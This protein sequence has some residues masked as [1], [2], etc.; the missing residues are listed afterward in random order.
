MPDAKT[1]SFYD[2]SA[3]RYAELTHSNA[4]SD[5]LKAFMALLPEG[6]SVLDLGCGPAQAS[7]YMRDKGF[8]PDPVDASQ[9]MIDLA[10]VRYNIGARKLTFDELDMVNTYDGVWANF[11]LLHTAR[12]NLPRYLGSIYTALHS[13]GVFHIAMKVGENTERDSLDRLY[14]YV[15][16]DELKGLLLDVGFDVLNIVEGLEI[17]C[18]GTNDS[19]VV[20]RAIK[21][22]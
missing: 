17:G 20:I 16:V 5:N 6:G 3:E 22:D 12:E 4:E 14:T 15:S 7:A 11:S 18:A 21:N 10:N 19:F 2:G 1:I 13:K 9:A 8:K